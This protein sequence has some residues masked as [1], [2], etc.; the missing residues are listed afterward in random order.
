MSNFIE[1]SLPLVSV[2]MTVFNAEKYLANSIESICHQTFRDWEFLIVDDASTDD[3]VKIAEE[4][5]L[6]D[7]RIRVIQN[8]LNKG[9]TACLNQGL[10]EARGK[11]IARQDADDLSLP[12]RLEQQIKC[13][14]HYPTLAL[15]GSCGF[16][17]DS[18]DHLVGLLDVPLRQE[19]IYWSAPIANP[20]LHTS[21]LFQR[22]I[23]RFLG[24]YDTTYHIAQ[25]YDLWGRLLAGGYET[26][27]LSERLICYRHL[28]HSLSQNNQQQTFQ[29]ISIISERLAKE[30]FREALSYEERA[31]L[32]GWRSSSEQIAFWNLYRKL[33]YSLIQ[34]NILI[35]KDHARFTAALYLNVAGSS[36]G[37][38][39]FTN[40]IAACVEDPGFVMYWISE[41]FFPKSF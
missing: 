26:K 3:S 25:D 8:D 27:N 31:L 23:V 5:A 22:D 29:E 13:V 41:R 24:G 36:S 19:V 30:I 28:S 4:Y 6:K 17:I 33:S 12:T 11:W 2:L 40:L 7:Q 16:M 37:V 14:A 38:S 15:V 20:F 39:R 1:T 34:E 18:L 10:N 9:Q 21:V 35:Q 32:Q